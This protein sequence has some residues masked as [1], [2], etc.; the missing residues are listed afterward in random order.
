[1]PSIKRSLLI[2]ATLQAFAAIAAPIPQLAGEGSACN[3]ALSSTDNG[4]GYG[5]ENALGMCYGRWP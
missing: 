2:L 5:T 4:V 3:S 1:M